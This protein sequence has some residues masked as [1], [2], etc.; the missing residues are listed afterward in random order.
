AAYIIGRHGFYGRDFVV[1]QGVLIPRPDTETLIEQ[2]IKRSAD[3]PDKLRIL[4]T[5]TGSGCIGIT[6]AL[7][8][9]RTGHQVELDLADIS[10]EALA[11]S[12]SNINAYS[13]NESTRIHQTNVWPDMPSKWDLITANPPYINR[14]L[15]DDLQPEVSV[16]EPM[17]ALDGGADGLDFY[18]VIY[19]QAANKLNP[20]GIIACEHGFDQAESIRQIANEYG[21]HN[22][23][24]YNDFGGNPRVT[25]CDKI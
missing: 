12:K 3:L 6:L 17:L 20:S 9:T 8:L 25:I 5:F 24:Q 19:S 22:I 16:K 10:A 2:V 4:D 21:W 15:I 18:R 23:Y 11:Y 1:G 13:L 14:G 7:E